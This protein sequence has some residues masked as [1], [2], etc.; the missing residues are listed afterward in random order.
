MGGNSPKTTL[1]DTSYQPDA[2]ARVFPIVLQGVTVTL[3]GA[4]GGYGQILSRVR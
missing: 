1:G 2:R 4:L 3:A